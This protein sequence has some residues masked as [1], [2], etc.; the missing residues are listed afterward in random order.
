MF[1]HTLRKQ[2]LKKCKLTLSKSSK[3]SISHYFY[4]NQPWKGDHYLFSTLKIGNN[5]LLDVG[6]CVAR[7]GAYVVVTDNAKLIIEQCT[8]NKNVSICCFKEIKIGKRVTISENVC[9]RDSDNHEVLRDGYIKTAPIC[10]EDDVWIGMNVTILKGVHI[11]KG[12]VISAGSVVNRDVPDHCLVG[13]VPAKVIRTNIEW[14][15]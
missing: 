8:I 13:G 6:E 5:A 2:S 4:Y 14:K 7:S 1:T 15:P 3:L 12:S 10:I 11:G 9:I